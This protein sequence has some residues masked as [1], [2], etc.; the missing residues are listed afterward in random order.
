MRTGRRRLRTVSSPADKPGPGKLG[1]AGAYAD[2]G[3]RFALAILISAGGGYW[4]DSKV[5]TLPLFTIVGVALGSASGLLTIY[6]A[7][8]PTEKKD[9][10]KGEGEP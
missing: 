7:V 10:T 6:R 9:L 2:L 3:L 1:P 5:G 4:V 8:Y